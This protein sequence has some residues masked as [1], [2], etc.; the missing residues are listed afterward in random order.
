MPATLSSPADAP[1]RL[2]TLALV[3]RALAD[4]TRLLILEHLAS[5][6]VGCCGDGICACDLEVLTGLS[7][8]T[9]SHHMRCLVGA[10]LVRAERRGKWM[11][12]SLDAPAFKAARGFINALN[13]C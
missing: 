4:E 10:G 13:C 12:Y 2:E 9:V 5:D 6:A 1:P 11:Y 8:P 7:Q 3:F